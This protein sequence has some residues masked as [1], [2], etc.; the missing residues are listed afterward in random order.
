MLFARTCIWIGLVIKSWL[1]TVIDYFGFVNARRHDTSQTVF[2]D[3]K[4][5]VAVISAVFVLVIAAFVWADP[6]FIE[7][8]MSSDINKSGI[9]GM[10]TDIGKSDWI[11]I[12]TGCVLLAISAYNFPRLTKPH[13]V[14]WHDIFLKFYFAFTAVGFSGLITI[15][16]KNLIGRARP[17]FFEN[18][19]T[20]YSSPFTDTYL[21]ASF[22]SGH[23]TTAAS[24]A[25]VLFLFAPR[26]A[27]IFAAM[28]VWVGITRIGLGAHFP[29]DV[30]AGLSVGAGFTWLYART[31]AQKRLLFEF[32]GPYRLKVRNAAAK[33]AGKKIGVEK[34]PIGALSI[35]VGTK[36]TGDKP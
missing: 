14:Y 36:L 34:N 22:P 33:R 18:P 28:A 24:L 29:S 9:F 32:D 25:M 1:E 31:F 13:Q 21:F 20:W 23:S 12:S 8:A 19:E 35:A 17:T 11:L 16:L 4:V 7:W 26:L 5:L 10:T 27:V 15:G 2:P 3:F 6:V 30:I